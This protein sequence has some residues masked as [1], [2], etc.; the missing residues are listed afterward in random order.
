[1]DMPAAVRA[2]CRYVQAGIRTAPGLGGGNGPLNHFHSVY[3]LPFSPYERNPFRFSFLLKGLVLADILRGHF[4]EYLLERPDVAHVWHTFVNHPFVLAMG[5]ATLPIES[6][7]GY[8][9]QDYLYLVRCP[10][11]FT[12]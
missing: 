2:G 3:T 4:I 5:D 12:L 11:W 7:K 10:R 8:L 9:I 6:F 1:M